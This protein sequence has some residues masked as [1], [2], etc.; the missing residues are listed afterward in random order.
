MAV[1]YAS[2]IRARKA[3]KKREAKAR[4]L[5]YSV[6]AQKIKGINTYERAALFNVF[7]QVA[8]EKFAKE[9]GFDKRNRWSLSLLL[10]VDYYTPFTI[11][12]AEVW[13]MFNTFDTLRTSLHRLIDKGY[14][15]REKQSKIYYLSIKGTNLLKEFRQYYKSGVQKINKQNAQIQKRRGDAQTGKTGSKSK[16]VRESVD[17]VKSKATGT[18]SDGGNCGESD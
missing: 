6:L 17:S 13:H 1:K 18:D 12:D 2:T 11:A 7:Y 5:A 9:H 15:H 16:R 3:Y 8:Y 10:V 14:L 4:K